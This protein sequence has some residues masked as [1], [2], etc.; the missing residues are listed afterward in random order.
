MEKYKSQVME[1]IEEPSFFQGIIYFGVGLKIGK[2]NHPCGRV[3][4]H[5]PVFSYGKIDPKNMKNFVGIGLQTTFLIP[6]IKE[7]KLIYTV[8]D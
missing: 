5:F 8:K 1:H 6:I 3:E 4:A 7:H 2:L